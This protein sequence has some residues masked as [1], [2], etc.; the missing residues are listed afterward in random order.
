MFMLNV[1]E[2]ALETELYFQWGHEAFSFL[3]AFVCYITAVYTILE[4]MQDW[5]IS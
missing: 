5:C 2:P 4:F 1:F 3:Q